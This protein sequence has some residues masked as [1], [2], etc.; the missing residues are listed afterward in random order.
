MRTFRVLNILFICQKM[1]VKWLFLTLCGFPMQ[2]LRH[3]C[4]RGGKILKYCLLGSKSA[5]PEKG[6]ER[7]REKKRESE[8]E[9]FS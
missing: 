3:G 5:S 6:G 8:R 9:R 2:Y 7:D 1:V 4:F